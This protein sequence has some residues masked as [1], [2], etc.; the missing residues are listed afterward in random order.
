M[1]IVLPFLC[2]FAGRIGLDIAFTLPFRRIHRS[3][4][5]TA[6]IYSKAV[7]AGRVQWSKR[8]EALDGYQ[9]VIS[10]LQVDERLLMRFVYWGQIG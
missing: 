1:L 7:P 10:L 2:F 3:S 9:G 6:W 4:S 8:A 5:N